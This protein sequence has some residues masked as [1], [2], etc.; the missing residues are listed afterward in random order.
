M[1][2]LP[3]YSE[4]E[5]GEER[6]FEQVEVEAY[7]TKD[8]KKALYIFMQNHGYDL[9]FEVEEEGLGS[10]KLYHARDAERLAA[11]DACTQLDRAGVLRGDSNANAERAK[12][13]KR[14]L[15]GYESDENL[16]YDPAGEVEKE[17]R[18]KKMQKRTTGKV[19]TFESLSLQYEKTQQK[20]L[21][22][23][24]QIS[25]LDCQ[26]TTDHDDEFAELIDSLKKDQIARDKKML[27]AS[28]DDLNLD[29][30]KIRKLIEFVNP[31]HFDQISDP[32]FLS[33]KSAQQLVESVPKVIPPIKISSMDPESPKPES[34]SKLLSTPDTNL[35]PQDNK[36]FEEEEDE[37]ESWVPP[38]GQTGDGRTFLNEKFGY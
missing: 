4:V 35:D 24:E 18:S 33:S 16:F 6:S 1:I 13:M 15:D 38:A 31:G 5:S 3:L 32:K 20:I 14:L 37:V 30:K 21:H 11:L 17:R 34:K 19:E 28:R 26:E 2:Q 25:K 12:R 22:I 7:Y 36:D 27:V 9:E 23:N 29:L 8:P 10:S